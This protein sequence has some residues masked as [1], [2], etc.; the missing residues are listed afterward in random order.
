MISPSQKWRSR[1]GQAM[2]EFTFVGIPLMFALISIFEISRGMWIYHTLAYS[3][4][5]GVRYASVHGINCVNSANN[6]NNCLVNIGPY[7]TVGTIGY[8]IS[9]AAVGL[10]P[11]K[12][13]LTFTDASGAQIKCTLSLC[14]NQ[15]WP[16]NGGIGGVSDV[17]KPIQ[18]DIRTPFI[19]AIAMFW[20]GAAP[21][22]FASGTLGASSQDYIQF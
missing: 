17:G 13:E 19:S 9:Q 16:P 14:T 3:V 5:N 21:L 2:V 7:N 20:P 4:K 1:A 12:T 10:D 22:G 15:Q 8:V 11:T 18:I 6:P